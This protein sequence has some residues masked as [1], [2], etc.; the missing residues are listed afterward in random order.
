MKTRVILTTIVS[1]VLLVAVVAAG[2]NAVFTVTLV[3]S[4]FSVYSGAG[5]EDALSLKADLERYV[6]D[7]TTFLDVEDV[8][9]TVKSYPCFEVETV[10]KHFPK[11]LK[12]K[13]SERKEFFAV[14]NGE[15]YAILD[16]NGL[17]LHD[18][19]NVNRLG[20][21][22]VLLD[23]FELSLSRGE[24]AEGGYIAEVF[25][26]FSVF[27][28][29]LPGVRANVVS[30]SLVSGGGQDTPEHKSFVVTMREGVKIAIRNPSADIA[31]KARAAF[32]DEE[33]GY[34]S[35]AFADKKRVY[36]A[37]S[38]NN[39]SPN[40]SVNVTFSPELPIYGG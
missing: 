23:G 13:V 36:G 12:V 39:V 10:E 28:E 1:F 34:L 33:A 30:V 29:L 16:E 9:D 21:M 26:M 6:G 35:D 15:T 20:G 5:R 31:V 4:E 18:G 37:I 38:V 11:T 14:P 2:L 24:R 17:Y 25:E 27:S 8:K 22:N 40:G 7:S 19:E 32:C 3:D